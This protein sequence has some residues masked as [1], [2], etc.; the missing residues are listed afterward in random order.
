MKLNVIVDRAGNVIGTA[1]TGLMK[2]D[3]GTVVEIEIIPEA[4]QTIYEVDVPDALARAEATAIHQKVGEIIKR[5]APR[6][7]SKH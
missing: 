2:L 6:W 5:T 1:T 3:D 7:G 4:D